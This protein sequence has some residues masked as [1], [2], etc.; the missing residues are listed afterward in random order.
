MAFKSVPNGESRSKTMPTTQIK[1]LSDTLKSNSDI[2]Q[3]FVFGSYAYG[4]PDEES[5]I[6]LCIVVDLNHRRKID[7][8][9]DI[10]RKL[11]DVI[12]QPLDILVYTASEFQERSRLP[13]TLEHK[14]L[15]NGLRVYG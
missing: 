4:A 14:I 11:M 6:D 9:R 1:L 3:I 8:I 10:R 2:K 15:M 12:M 13:T 5:D 7:I